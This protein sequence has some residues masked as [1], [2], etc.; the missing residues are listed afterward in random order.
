MRR[1]VNSKLLAAALA[2]ALTL[3]M[4]VT[5]FAAWPSFQNARNNN[6]VINNGTPPTDPATAATPVPLPQGATVYSGVDAAPV[7]NTATYTDASGAQSTKTI[8]YTLYD[9]G[10]AA[11]GGARVAAVDVAAGTNLW[12][13]QLNPTSNFQV[14]T[15]YLDTDTNILYAGV[16][17]TSPMMTLPPIFK[18]GWTA[19]DGASI[20]TSGKA[21]FPAGVTSSISTTESINLMKAVNT[22]YAPTDLSVPA[23]VTADYE[24]WLEPVPPTPPDP[25]EPPRLIDSG[26]INGGDDGATGTYNTYNADTICE[27]I[28]YTVRIEVTPQGGAVTATN[29]NLN[30]YDW[31]LFAISGVNTAN[32][33]VSASLAGAEGEF[34]TPISYDYDNI[35]WGLWGGVRSYYQYARDGKSAPVVFTPQ[36]PSVTWH[37]DNFYGAGAFSNDADVFFGSDSGTIYKQDVDDFAT[38]GTSRNLKSDKADVGMIRST[39][40]HK[41]TYNYFTSHGT[42]SVGYLWKVDVNL[43]LPEYTQLTYNSTSTPVISDNNIIYVGTYGYNTVLEKG[44]GAVEAFD[45][46]LSRLAIIYGGDDDSDPVQSSP[47]VWSK[48]S[49]ED[50]IY[51]TTNAGT[52]KGKGY[53]FYYDITDPTSASEEWAAGG[54]SSN[55]FALQGFASDNG[56]LVYGDDGNC[57]YI[58]H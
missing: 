17:R 47:I 54:T 43:T 27:N 8:A 16:T 21:T 1:F 56:Y 19:S 20:D 33:T 42:G 34:N 2:V 49:T 9:A 41:G 45:S 10:N 48:N 22:I 29:I 4:S 13:V 31:D 15:P 11:G 37:G 6:G 18:Y 51:F 7:M 57:L 32:P 5:A 50:Y 30:R 12:D 38:P 40:A 36:L 53:C 35:Y 39:I 44:I 28:K 3:A 52:E 25:P 14:S 46:N 55:P 24:I 58:M 26:T 23:G